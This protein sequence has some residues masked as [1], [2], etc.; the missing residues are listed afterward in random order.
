MPAAKVISKKQTQA[1]PTASSSDKKKED[2]S[3]NKITNSLKPKP[4]PAAGIASAEVAQKAEVV[5]VK[6]AIIPELNN[7]ATGK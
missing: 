1:Q 3:K 2:D 4:V 5:V 6:A 7:P